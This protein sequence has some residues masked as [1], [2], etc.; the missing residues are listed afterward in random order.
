M[1]NKGYF[2]FGTLMTIALVL[3][4]AWQY[5]TSAQL[6]NGPLSLT[7]S[8]SKERYT[9]GEVVDFN[10]ELKNVTTGPIDVKRPSVA[11]GTVRIQMSVDGTGFR[12][13]RGPMWRNG[14]ASTRP[15]SLEKASAIAGRGTILFNQTTPSG[16]LT[17]LYASRIQREELEPDFVVSSA[18]TYY[19]KAIYSDGRIVTESEPIRVEFTTPLGSDSM[20]W[21]E[22]R[23]E[24]AYAYFLQTGDVLYDPDSADAESFRVDV[25]RIV[26]N[27]PDSPIAIRLGERLAQY[28]RM[29]ESLPK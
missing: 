14:D 8:T 25:R 12:D 19:L 27:Y 2:A 5:Q 7:L 15:V 22:I 16:H 20:V 24:G 4:V 18:G 11:T 21:D 6:N 29:L 17:E 28:D 13:Y 23:I 3:A 1:K 9:I 26:A 10:F